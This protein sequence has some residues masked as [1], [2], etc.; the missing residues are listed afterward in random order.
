MARRTSLVLISLV[1]LFSLLVT[2]CAPQAT[3]V[4]PTTAAPAQ[5]QAATVTQ[6]TAAP[7]AE[8]AKPVITV[9]G[10]PFTLDELQ[11]FEQVTYEFEDKKYA[12]ASMLAVLDAAGV[13]VPAIVVVASDGYSANVNVAEIT[14]Q[15]V[16]S[17]NKA[18]GVD[19]AFPGVAK[20][21]W[22]RDVVE[23]KEGLVGGGTSKTPSA[24]A[25]AAGAAP[26]ATAAPVGE[27]IEL[28][29]AAGR[30]VKLPGTP[31]R[32]AVVGR[33][34]H[35]TLHVLYMFEE[36]RERLVGMEKRGATA[37]DFL[38]A[39]DPQFSTKPTLDANPNVEQIATLK[40]DLVIMKSAVPDEV[41]D[42]LAQA[43]I[44]FMYVNLETPD[45]FFRDLKNIGVVLANPQRA[46][47]IAAFYRTRLDNLAQ[48]TAGLPEGDKPSVLLLEYTDR[49]GEL[50]VKVPAKSWMQTIQVQT[51]GGK[52]V[53]LEAAAATSGWTVVNLEQL[54][55]W[56][57]DKIFLVIWYTL[58]P[59]QVIDGLKADPQW[60]TLKAV[61]NNEIYA[62]PQDI[63][64]WDQPEP[65]W[66]LGMMWLGT[67]IYPDRFN[68][69][70]MQAEINAY[71]GEL[72]G[73]DQ[74]AI[75]TIIMPKVLMDVQ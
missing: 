11:A 49:G 19:S 20:N 42:V 74:A 61:K 41:G 75:D 47:E 27:P 55:S 10:K 1:V 9:M 29:D 51:A 70:D 43:N 2:G 48:A 60:S 39:I 13:T 15:A 57:P 8:A 12:G 17:F 34:P 6:P 66:I 52:P 62:F 23:I 73:M 7:K 14:D 28:T 18:G 54:A 63:F 22:V 38:T 69:V 40:P 68:D 26:A 3:T 37:S 72:F 65:R 24:E 67:R 59:Q 46:E 31:Q 56:N 25:G 33:G 16:L 30:T 4:A 36:G 58:D 21:T 64:G 35:M 5:Q 71:F 50:A 32:I 45:E 53:W 44:P